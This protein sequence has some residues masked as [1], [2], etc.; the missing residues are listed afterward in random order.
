ML[1][2]AP[3]N[4]PGHTAGRYAYVGS[5]TSP[6]R[7]GHGR[8]I[9]V[10]DT[11]NNWALVHHVPCDN[12]TYLIYGPTRDVLYCAHGDSPHISAF[13]V[14]HATGT[15]TL[16]NR[17][18]TGGVNPVHL[19]VTPDHRYLL[20]ANHNSGTVSSIT[21][22]TGGRLGDIVH[23]LGMPGDP[24]P[25]RTAQNGSKPHQVQ[26]DPTGTFAVVPDKGL[27]A[28][29][30]LTVDSSGKLFLRDNLTVKAREMSGPRH[31]VFHPTRPYLYSV[32]EFRST[33]THY[34]YDPRTYRITT[35]QIVSSVPDTVTGDTRAAEIAIDSTG[36]T[37]YVSN[38]GGAGD[39]T[40]GGEEPDT[41]GVFSIDPASGRL[42]NPDWTETG[43]IRPRFFCLDGQGH[44]I[45]A[46]ERSD[47]IA[48][49]DITP[50][51]GHL[52][53]PRHLADTGSPVA[54]LI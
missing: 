21:L 34:G 9:E 5:R 53:K 18:E 3:L 41:I 17:I 6:E 35:R 37:L 20:V 19:A 49:H 12:P 42:T 10:F 27:D 13:T 45:A 30:I 2:P 44:L 43:G 47:S 51:T 33:V 31:V 11:A 26:F 1:T 23:I 48:I 32:E 40:P 4:P 8:G 28:L 15:L 54:V 50:G 38:R 46:H 29:F 22:E 7:D 16:L 25:H 24:G 14:D 39:H 36:G 52:G